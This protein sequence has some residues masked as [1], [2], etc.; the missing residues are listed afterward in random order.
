MRTPHAPLSPRSCRVT[1]ALVRALRT[2]LAGGAR[3]LPA[4]P[5]AM[6]RRAC[7]LSERDA[8]HAWLAT[9][10]SWIG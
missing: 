9:Q 5:D 1:P 4:D 6:T 8:E 10:A 7:V 3:D 2:W